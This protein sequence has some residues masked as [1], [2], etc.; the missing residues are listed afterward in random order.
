MPAEAADGSLCLGGR[1]AGRPG[2]VVTATV[3]GRGRSDA[4]LATQPLSIQRPC[5]HQVRRQPVPRPSPATRSPTSNQ[6]PRIVP[7]GLRSFDEHDADFFLELLPG[8]RDRDG[9]PESIRFWKLRIEETDPDK[10]FRVGL[11][12]GPSGCGKSSLVKAGLLPRLAPHVVPVYVE[13]AAED[14]ELRLL[15]G[16][17]R[18]FATIP[19]E[20]ALPE[21]LAGIREGPWVPAE[22]E[23]LHRA[24]PVRAVAACAARRTGHAAGAGPA[25]LRRRA[26][27][28]RGAGAG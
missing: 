28:V 23:G 25:S 26:A 8:A 1:T 27:A 7:K 16:L 21:V 19:D 20:L 2:G 6:P 12:Y 18:R 3:S 24:G 10:T 17:R 4:R 9:L 22:H 15:K 14:T 11:I 5:T 13:A